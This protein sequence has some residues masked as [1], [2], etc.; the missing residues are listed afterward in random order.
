MIFGE[1]L[2][3]LAGDAIDPAVADV[4]DVGHG[5]LDDHRGEGA[6]VALVAVV[7]VLAA[8]CLGVEP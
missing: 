7:A 3:R 1:L 4:K 8:V 2:E 6:D 5:R